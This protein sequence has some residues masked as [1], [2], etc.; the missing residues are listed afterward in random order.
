MP[1]FSNGAISS[2]KDVERRVTVQSSHK[3]SRATVSSC[4]RQFY[5]QFFFFSSPPSS[6]AAAFLSGI[7]NVVSYRMFVRCFR[8]AFLCCARG[9]VH[10]FDEKQHK[11]KAAPRNEPHLNR[12]VFESSRRRVLFL[13]L[14]RPRQNKR[15]R[16]VDRSKGSFGLSLRMGRRRLCTVTLCFVP[17]MLLVLMLLLSS[18]CITTA[19]VFF[20]INDCSTVFPRYQS[21]RQVPER[22]GLRRGHVVGS[23]AGTAR[24][25]LRQRVRRHGA[26]GIPGAEKVSFF[27]VESTRQQV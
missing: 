19:E 18:I 13:S 6:W 21:G 25:V 26:E 2:S 24:H 22:N 23:R 16:S 10:P 27:H 11:K 7:L 20:F 4:N 12:V 5:V 14:V 17:L 9:K 15:P 1:V 3:V 8:F